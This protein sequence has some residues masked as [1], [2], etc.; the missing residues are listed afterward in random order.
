MVL[1]AAAP[2]EQLFVHNGG[3]DE[4]DRQ[5]LDDLGLSDVRSHLQH[6]HVLM[7]LDRGLY[8]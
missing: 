3:E 2:L 8:R 5:L 4:R 1:L 6:I 7:F